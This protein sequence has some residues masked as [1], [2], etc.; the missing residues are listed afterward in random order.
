MANSN[1]DLCVSSILGFPLLLVFLTPPDPGVD[2]DVLLPGVF[3]VFCGV[4]EGLP[5]PLR[6]V[7]E[8]FLTSFEHVTDRFPRPPR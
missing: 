1:L 2:V 4:P 8:V 5:G 7:P 3:G 6:L